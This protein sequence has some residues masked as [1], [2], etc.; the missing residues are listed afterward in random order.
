MSK[1]LKKRLRILKIFIATVIITITF[2]SLS[3]AADTSS[4]ALPMSGVKSINFDER[5]NMYEVIGT[6]G[7]IN[8]LSKDKRYF[9]FGTIIDT[10]EKTNLTEER[11]AEIFKINFSE[12]SLQDAIKLP[13]K[14]NGTKKIAAFI[15]PSCPWCRKLYGEFK[16][17]EDVTV[18]VF[19]TPLSSKN[20]IRSLWCS[21]DIAIIDQAFMR[22]TKEIKIQ[23]KE[24]DSSAIDRNLTFIK[25]HGIN[26]YPTII[27]EN[28]KRIAGYVPYEKLVKLINE[29]SLNTLS[30]KEGKR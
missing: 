13:S 7:T 14:K 25:T 4:D 9:F 22:D 15:D 20:V 18:Y 16:K 2:F 11:K 27:F 23:A 19:L 24:C 30:R 5:I 26:S 29:N 17:F 12:L 6:D 3:N 21:K 8:Y 28:G 10:K 1:S